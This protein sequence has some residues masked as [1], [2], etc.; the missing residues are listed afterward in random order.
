MNKQRFYAP[1]KRL[2]GLISAVV[3]ISAISVAAYKVSTPTANRGVSTKSSTPTSILAIV[4][5]LK[6]QLLAD[7]SFLRAVPPV[8][9]TTTGFQIPGDNFQLVLPVS[10]PSL[11]Y[12]DISSSEQTAFADFSKGAT[13]INGYLGL[14]GF[15]SV[16]K[17]DQI[18]GLSSAVYFYKR[19]DAICQLSQYTSLSL[20]CA[21]ISEL[22]LIAMQAQPLVAAYDTAAPNSGTAIVASPVIRSSK[23]T[24]YTI[25]TLPIYN[26]HGETSANFY[27]QGSGTWHIVNLNWYNDPQEDADIVPNCADFESYAPV[28]AAFAGQACY[29]SV[30]RTTRAI[31]G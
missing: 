6:V 19:S 20:T 25:A 9:Q 8:A 30:I 15:S 12:T 27:K 24:G 23:T 22:A 3:V 2:L 18:S 16:A 11:A 1:S 21:P 10:S 7:Y 4:S 5:T 28:R 13:H 26:N 17:Q 29:D 14:H 31:R